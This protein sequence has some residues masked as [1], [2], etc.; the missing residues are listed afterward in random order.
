M[1]DL[2][3]QT[4]WMIFTGAPSSGKTT[5]L[6]KLEKRGFRVKYEV[7]RDYIQDNQEKGISVE[8]TRK[9]EGEFQE[10]VLKKKIDLEDGLNPTDLVVLDR[11]L[12]D[13]LAYYDVLG[14]NVT[15]ISD[16]VSQRKYK[17]VFYFE[18]LEFV[19]D[20]IR[21]ES[22]VDTENIDKKL[23]QHYKAQGYEIIKVPIF[24]EEK[25]ESIEKRLEFVEMNI[26]CDRDKEA[27]TP[28]EE[29]K[30]EALFKEYDTLRSEMKLY[31]SFLRMDSRILLL[32]FGAIL[33]LVNST[34]FTLIGYLQPIIP[35]A[36]FVFILSQY[37]SLH[38]ISVEAKACANIEKKINNL[39]CEEKLMSW[40][41]FVA[42]D[43]V[44]GRT[45]VTSL[46]TLGIILIAVWVFLLSAY[47]VSSCL[48]DSISILHLLEAIIIVFLFAA[49]LR[50]EYQ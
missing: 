24:S 40:E 14:K 6:A 10:I 8:E 5:I 17:K 41:H 15:K 20:G 33:A 46:S 47:N 9:N 32:A 4:N 50:Y 43:S 18:R 28:I 11:S 31:L 2:R 30:L 26:R 27:L 13:T 36:V 45:T 48:T 38:M 25:E 3:E 21:N 44:R 29:K 23:I 22:E 39:L 35:T 37:M 34:S 19:D 42:K 49:L 1:K 7:A 12:I 16:I